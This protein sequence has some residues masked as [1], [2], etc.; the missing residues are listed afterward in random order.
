M[1]Q[2]FFDAL[3][4]ILIAVVISVTILT[5]ILYGGPVLVAHSSCMKLGYP[6][7]SV[8]LALNL[9][10]VDRDV[11]IRLQDARKHSK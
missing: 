3:L 4:D 9:H 1:I 8:D 2:R 5:V 11:V 6:S 10:C 7:A